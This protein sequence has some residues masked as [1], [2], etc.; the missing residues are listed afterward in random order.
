MGRFRINVILKGLIPVEM[1]IE[2]E[3]EMTD[4]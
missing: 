1:E 3:Y 2:Y 4:Y